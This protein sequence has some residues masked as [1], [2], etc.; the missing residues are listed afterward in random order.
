MLFL[1]AMLVKVFSAAL[2][3]SCLSQSEMN[4]QENIVCST[5]KRFQN[6]KA[7]TS[8]QHATGAGCQNTKLVS[9]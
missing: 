5:C 3:R 6:T 8:E 4:L 7:A 1:F 2:L 9:F